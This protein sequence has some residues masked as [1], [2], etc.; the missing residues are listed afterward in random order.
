MR[1]GQV[2]RSAGVNVQTLRYYER[3]GLLK[4][5][6]RLDSGYRAYSPDAVDS[7]RF[8][9]RAQELG[10]ALTEIETL[11]DL[12]NGGPDDCDRAQA[13]ARIKIAE[14][15]AKIA[16]LQAMRESLGRHVATC[17][18]PRKDRQCPL[19]SSIAVVSS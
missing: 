4:R 18:L 6:K 8:I 19:V 2:A 1:S 16:N 13:L 5:P 10:F 14:M 11:L 17:E 7:V 9:K 12:S 15:E 3:R